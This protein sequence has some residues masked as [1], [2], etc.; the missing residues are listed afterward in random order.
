M[1][2]DDVFGEQRKLLKPRLLGVESET[3]EDVTVV[4]HARARFNQKSLEALTLCGL[5]RFL[6]PP[7]AFFQLDAP[8]RRV[9]AFQSFM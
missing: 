7:L 2:A 5:D 6:R 3:L 4:G 8:R 9:M 1:L